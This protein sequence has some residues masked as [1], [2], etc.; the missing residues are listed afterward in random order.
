MNSFANFSLSRYQ[1]EKS[2]KIIPYAAS[3]RPRFSS[4]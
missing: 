3:S 1:I 2:E 4:G